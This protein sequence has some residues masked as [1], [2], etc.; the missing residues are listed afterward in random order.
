VVTSET[1]IHAERWPTQE[2][3]RRG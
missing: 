3:Q 2:A 1:F